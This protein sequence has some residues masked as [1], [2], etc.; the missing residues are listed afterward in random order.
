M[1]ERLSCASIW[2]LG[3]MRAS[4]TATLYLTATDGGGKQSGQPP[5]RRT[6]Y[7]F[8]IVACVRLAQSALA[9]LVLNRH[10]AAPHGH[11]DSA[12]VAAARLPGERS[13]SVDAGGAASPA[14]AY[15]KQMRRSAA[16][17]R[18]PVNSPIRSAPLGS[19]SRPSGALN[20]ESE[21]DSGRPL[22]G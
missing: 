17:T 19:L 7:P 1:K 6:I 4:S 16:R 12:R 15:E 5:L 10:G 11:S 18:R 22:A 13:V 20:T 2:Q 14:E 8:S 21:I 3:A 9:A